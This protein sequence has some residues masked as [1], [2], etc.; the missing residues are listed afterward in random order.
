MR[1]KQEVP[2]AARGTAALVS[3]YSNVVRA[4]NHVRDAHIDVVDDNPH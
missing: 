3:E 2:H 1:Q 4:A